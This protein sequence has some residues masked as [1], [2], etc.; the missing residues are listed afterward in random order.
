M[1][2]NLKSLECGNNNNY[3]CRILNLLHMY[4]AQNPF[5]FVTYISVISVL[6]IVFAHFRLKFIQDPQ[7]PPRTAN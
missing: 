3:Y 5:K 7:S 2:W 4:I 6:K 1:P